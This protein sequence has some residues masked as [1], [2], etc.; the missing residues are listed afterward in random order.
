MR[1]ELDLMHG[2]QLE[3]VEIRFDG[4]KFESSLTLINLGPSLIF[5]RSRFGLLNLAKSIVD[6]GKSFWILS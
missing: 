4:G 1:L 2:T 3:L 5:H 6:L